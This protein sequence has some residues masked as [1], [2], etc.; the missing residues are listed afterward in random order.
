MRFSLFFLLFFAYYHGYSQSVVVS[1]YFNAGDTRDEWI[2][3]LIIQDQTSLI[4]FTLRDNNASQTGWQDSVIFANHSLWTNLRAGTIIV[5][6]N[7]FISSS[8]SLNPIDTNGSDGYIEVNAQLSRIF[9]GGSF[10]SSPS[11]GGNTLSIAGGGELIQIR[12]AS[13]AHVHALG[14]RN[15]SGTNFNSLSS[16]KLNHASTSSSGESIRV[17]PGANLTDY[18]GF[19]G[20]TLTT[21]NSSL[22]T[23]GLPNQS[24]TDTSSNLAFWRLLRQPNYAGPNLNAIIANGSFNQFSLIWN[25]CADPHPTDSTIGYI[26]LRNTS[27]T[28]SNPIDGFTYTVGQSI[29]SASVVGLVNYSQIAQFTDNTQL[30]CGQTFFYKIYAFRYKTDQSLGLA[31]HSSRGRAYNETGTNVQSISRPQP[32]PISSILAY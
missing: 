11:W 25:A 24:S 9:T 14:H 2:E 1:E 4:G 13:N 15:L 19:S 6:W 22:I 18:N 27:N 10:G 17:N 8:S 28:F 30:N 32:S 21:K 12:N 3:L 7:R 26:I 29:G 16:P 20:T 5:I 31:Y 23:L